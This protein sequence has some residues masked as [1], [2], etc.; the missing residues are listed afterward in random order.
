MAGGLGADRYVVDSAGDVVVELSGEGNDSVIATLNWV[1]GDNLEG[2]VLNGTADLIGGGND[3]ANRLTGNSG[4]NLLA[5]FAGRDVLIGQAG[6]DTLVGG[7][8]GDV[9]T[10]GADADTF[11]FEA[12]GDGVDR[13]TDFT[14]GVDRIA[15]LQTGFGLPIGALDPANFVAH[16][17]NVA[18]SPFG[19]QQFIYN[20]ALGILSFDGDGLGGAA[21]IRLAVLTG[22]PALIVADIVIV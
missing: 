1:L 9:L 4:N 18:T 15:A 16:A 8:G 10:G 21:A 22:A 2:L 11:L 20:T 14:S 6:A 5:G 3:L 7:A 13:L 19:T 12:P 17:S